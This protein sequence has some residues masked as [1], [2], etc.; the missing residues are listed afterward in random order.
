MVKL[1]AMQITMAQI[2]ESSMIAQPGMPE[3]ASTVTTDQLTSAPTMSTSP[4]AKLMR[5]MM[6]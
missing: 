1:S 3:S 2:S 4:W 5:L 6:P